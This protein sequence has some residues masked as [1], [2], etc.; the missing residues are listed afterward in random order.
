M[1]LGPVVLLWRYFSSRHFIYS[2]IDIEHLSRN[3]V[4]HAVF[5]VVLALMKLLDA[6]VLFPG[7]LSILKLKEAFYL[8][9]SRVIHSVKILGLFLICIFQ[10]YIQ[11][12]FFHR[13]AESDW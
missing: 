1:S 4:H 12:T 8:L 3:T 7:H 2:I 11:N 5:K 9:G 13:S 10:A 6:F